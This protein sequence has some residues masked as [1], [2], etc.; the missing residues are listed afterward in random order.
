VK[1]FVCALCRC[2]YNTDPDWTEEAKVAELHANFIGHPPPED[3][4]T[5]CD[6]C[7]ARVIAKL[8]PVPIAEPI[9]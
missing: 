1:S 4:E 5:V 9:E 3:C 8:G 2:A 6:D 7:Y